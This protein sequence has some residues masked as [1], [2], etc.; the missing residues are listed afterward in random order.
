MRLYKNWDSARR[1]DRLPRLRDFDFAVLE[2]LGRSCFLLVA[3]EE[4]EASR[5]RY[6]G[7]D[8]AS[9]VGRDLTGHSLSD[10]PRSSLL[11]RVLGHHL[12]V[13]RRQRPAGANGRFHSPPGD[14]LYRAILLPF[15]SNGDQ[16]DAV[17]GCYRWRSAGPQIAA[18]APRRAAGEMNPQALWEQRHRSSEIGQATQAHQ[19]LLELVDSANF[20]WSKRHDRPV[21]S[22]GPACA[23]TKRVDPPM[24]PRTGLST[25]ERPRKTRSDKGY[26]RGFGPSN[27]HPTAVRP[28][29]GR[30]ILPQGCPG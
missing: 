22:S 10:V 6:F 28:V 21:R 27:L 30:E 29:G 13:T 14:L 25:L 5:F 17:L 18:D 23:K 20:I 7:R 4:G 11:S 26:P 8:L 12:E 19:E 24:M 2:E 3:G 9:E 15:S 16:V 1:W